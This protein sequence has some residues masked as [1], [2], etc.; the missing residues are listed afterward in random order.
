M[1]NLKYGFTE[2]ELA[3]GT[4]FRITG[5]IL[6]PDNFPSVLAWAGTQ[7]LFSQGEIPWELRSKV[8]Y[9]APAERLFLHAYLS[10]SGTGLKTVILQSSG[11]GYPNKSRVIDYR[12]SNYPF[13]LA[14]V[15]PEYLIEPWGQDINGW[16]I[17]NAFTRF[18]HRTRGD[19]P[20][21]I[22]WVG[23]IL[24]R[25]NMETASYNTF[26]YL[27]TVPLDENYEPMQFLFTLSQQ[28]FTAN[29]SWRLLP[30]Y[31]TSRGLLFPARD[32]VDFAPNR[33]TVSGS[34]GRE[35][36]YCMV[37]VYAGTDGLTHAEVY[38]QDLP[39]DTL[40]VIACS[41]QHLSGF[42]AP[43]PTRVLSPYEGV[44]W[45]YVSDTNTLN[46]VNYS[47]KPLS[48]VPQF[49]AY[50]YDGA[51]LVGANFGHLYLP[52]SSETFRVTL[53]PQLSAIFSTTDVNTRTLFKYG[54][55]PFTEIAS[56]TYLLNLP[57]EDKF[58]ISA[59]DIGVMQR[60]MFITYF[61]K[62]FYV[63]I[64]SNLV[65]E[66]LRVKAPSG[67]VKVGL[68]SPCAPQFP[69]N[70]IQA[71]PVF[72]TFYYKRNAPAKPF[73]AIRISHP[74]FL[75]NTSHLITSLF[76]RPAE[77]GGQDWIGDR[78]KIFI[79]EREKDT[80]TTIENAVLSVSAG[81]VTVTFDAPISQRPLAFLVENP[82]YP[83]LHAGPPDTNYVIADSI[84]QPSLFEKDISGTG[85][86]VW[87]SMGQTIC[88]RSAA[89]PPFRIRVKVFPQ[90]SNY[91]RVLAYPVGG[92]G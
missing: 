7:V 9:S 68:V 22:L 31:I 12:L 83:F 33:V 70:Y 6:I 8:L 85:A 5:E 47:N 38:F 59:L 17:A 42:S 15:P 87:V 75:P 3:D 57:T 88:R 91:I 16:W 28:H 58:F 54:F 37:E 65:E 67:G 80:F 39:D 79:L 29:Y 52:V 51:L 45:E 23:A 66:V 78:G 48:L 50:S 62:V 60:R 86:G 71:M 69:Q 89:E 32:L 13:T 77:P 64:D 25:D 34:R 10:Y 63:D 1:S 92:E 53:L 76:V 61:D 24:V 81:A 21:S 74:I 90:N 19:T 49:S 11:S 43:E 84:K 44:Y 26:L 36:A 56:V 14:S 41:E 30:V 2:I 18:T 35:T 4:P 20:F 82:P 55:L 46:L 72:S 27:C 73:S 40:P